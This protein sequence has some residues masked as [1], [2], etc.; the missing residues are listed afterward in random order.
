MYI[1]MRH[2]NKNVHQ[3]FSEKRKRPSADQTEVATMGDLRKL[4]SQ[5][6]M[7]MTCLK[8]DVIRELCTKLSKYSSNEADSEISSS[9]KIANLSKYLINDPEEQ[10]DPPAFLPDG[11]EDTVLP[12]KSVEDFRL[13]CDKLNDSEYFEYQVN[14]HRNYMAASES[15]NT[16]KMI[17]KLLRGLVDLEVRALFNFT[18]RSNFH[19]VEKIPDGFEKFVLTVLLRTDP[20]ADQSSLPKLFK[21][22]WNRSTDLLKKN[23]R[24]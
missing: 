16:Q 11:M 9:M 15:E 21:N 18:G 23:V 3:I 2:S 24:G 8:S 1:L 17:R 10:F 20:M 6:I 19:N 14:V 7:Q 4:K 13:Y 22:I 12:V 5:L